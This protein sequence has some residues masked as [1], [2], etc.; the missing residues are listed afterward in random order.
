LGAN[1]LQTLRSLG[2][3]A[4]VLL[5]SSSFFGAPGLT[6][7][8]ACTGSL[9]NHLPLGSFDFQTNSRVERSNDLQFP[10]QSVSCV[11]NNDTSYE[12]YVNWPIAGVHGWIPPKQ[13][14]PSVPRLSGTNKAIQL[15]SCIEYGNRGD[16]TAAQFFGFDRE[17]L[18]TDAETRVGCRKAIKVSYAGKALTSSLRDVVLKLK[19]FLVS[20]VTRP[21]VSMLEL[22]GGVGVVRTGEDSYVSFLVYEIKRYKQSDGQP[23]SITLKPSFEGDNEI[24]L[25]AFNQ[26]YREP[27]RMRPQGEISFA[28]AGGRDFVLSYASYQLFDQSSRLVASIDFPVFIPT[29]R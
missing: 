18:L 10:F 1:V 5:F 15:K 12:V 20:D 3:R 9:P 8:A 2:L 23:E 29:A 7:P 22:N 19:L 16:T 21:Q 14:L 28:F 4:A 13:T 6:Q 17:K 25:P 26:K 11:I 27:V 24:L